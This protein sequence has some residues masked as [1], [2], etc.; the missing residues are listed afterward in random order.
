MAEGNKSIQLHY[1][2]EPVAIPQYAQGVLETL[3]GTQT[4]I[5]IG[6]KSDGNQATFNAT[7]GPWSV[8]DT[9]IGPQTAPTG[10]GAYSSGL[11]EFNGQRLTINNVSTKADAVLLV[12]C[13][14][15]P[16]GS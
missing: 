5:Q 10:S 4:L 8:G 11:V 1:G 9:H 6:N 14:K 16:S 13:S 2:P 15:G 12:V 3:D 7:C